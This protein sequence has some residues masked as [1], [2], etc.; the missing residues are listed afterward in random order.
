MDNFSGLDSDLFSAASAL[1][2]ELLLEALDEGE[3]VVVRPRGLRVSGVQLEDPRAQ[4]LAVGHHPGVELRVDLALRLDQA[5]PGAVEIGRPPAV[6][7][8]Q[9]AALARWGSCGGRSARAAVTASAR[10]WAAGSPEG[11]SVPRSA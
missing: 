10:S 8:A 4:R 5:L 1:G 11:S 6:G 2:G 3:R 7:R 9:M